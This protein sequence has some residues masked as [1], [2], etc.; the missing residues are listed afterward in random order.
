MHQARKDRAGLCVHDR[1]YP[2]FEKREPIF[3]IE[4]DDIVETGGIDIS[5]FEA[6]VRLDSFA[7][8]RKAPFDLFIAE[9]GANRVF[10]LELIYALEERGSA[11]QLMFKGA[12][13]EPS[14]LVADFDFEIFVGI[15]FGAQ[16]DCGTRPR[17]GSILLLRQG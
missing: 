9:L 6:V 17:P 7:R 8:S 5:I 4:D 13:L 1:R 2:W 10:A 16:L 14:V 3:V 12:R 11:H 15:L